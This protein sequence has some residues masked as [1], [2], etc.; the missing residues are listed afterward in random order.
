MPT[1]KGTTPAAAG[2]A[3][4]LACCVGFQY[5]LISDVGDRIQGT[6][7][8]GGSGTLMSH[9]LFLP[10]AVRRLTGGMAKTSLYS[11]LVS[12]RCLAIGAPAAD[13]RAFCRTID[14]PM[15]A[16]TAQSN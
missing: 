16:R 10:L 8:T 14:I 9:F 12:L 11:S 2:V 3:A 1:S 6:T 4:N 15:V 5:L 7:L 13:L